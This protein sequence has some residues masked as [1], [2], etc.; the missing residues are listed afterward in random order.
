MTA[1]LFDPPHSI[2][3]LRSTASTGRMLNALTVDVEDYYH[4]SGFETC[5]QRQDWDQYPSRVV[6]NT[7]R[8]LTCLESAG[9]RATFF[10]LGWVAERHPGL[11]RR[12]VRF[13]HEVG[14]HSY[15][16]QLVYRQSQEQFRADLRRARTVIESASGVRVT[17]YRA[18]SFSITR[19]STWA[20]EVL[21]EEGFTLDSSIYPVHHDRYGLPG[22]PLEPHPRDLTGLRLWEFPPPVWNTLGCRLPV[23]GGG[24]FRL[25][26]YW[27][28]RRALRQ[29]NEAGRPFSFYIHPWEVDP[30]QPRLRPGW[31]RAFRHYVNLNRTESR[32]IRLLQDFRFGTL[33]AALASWRGVST[34]GTS[35]PATT[36]A[37]L[38]GGGTRTTERSI[39][40]AA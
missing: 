35:A 2:L 40:S 20:L 30:E 37:T 9:V 28:T 14:C 19:E 1:R 23:G 22:T 12:I 18:P 34:H 26:P 11:V 32:L 25:Y 5:V 21:A 15:W 16:H 4:V 10:I 3:P 29:I 13:G 38:I 36:T 6:A 8:L 31:L 7:E 17:A 39:A 24:Y 27:L 33:S